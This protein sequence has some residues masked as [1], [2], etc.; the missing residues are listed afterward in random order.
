MA[1]IKWTKDRLLGVLES[2]KSGKTKAQISK[3]IGLSY[4]RTRSLIR[5]AIIISDS[6]GGP[7][8]SELKPRLRGIV[9]AMGINT[10]DEFLS[11]YENGVFLNQPNFRKFEL[12]QV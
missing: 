8:L 1:K 9:S 3:D 11:A 2:Y 4:E 7:S 12:N 5:K 6:D 10:V